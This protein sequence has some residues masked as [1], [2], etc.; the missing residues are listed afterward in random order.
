MYKILLCVV[1]TFMALHIEG[2]ED[3]SPYIKI[4]DPINAL[5]ALPLPLIEALGG[6]EGL[7]NFPREVP[8]ENS[9]L[10]IQ[11]DTYILS[12][13]VTTM[14]IRSLHKN[15][16]YNLGP[17][18]KEILYKPLTVANIILEPK[19]KLGKVK[20]SFMFVE[21]KWF[22]STALVLISGGYW[23]DGIDGGVWDVIDL[24]AKRFKEKQQEKTQKLLDLLIKPLIGETVTAEGPRIQGSQFP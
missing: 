3:N 5:Q 13:Q 7:K 15:R 10:G 17:Q 9:A 24:G 11:K 21:R 23:E 14:D 20:F 12:L 18:E 16:G 8:L 19:S 4:L 2:R 1:L 6:E 22:Q